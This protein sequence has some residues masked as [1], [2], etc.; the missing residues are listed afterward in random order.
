MPACSYSFAHHV[1]ELQVS[2]A[3]CAGRSGWR[4]VAALCGS[5]VRPCAWAPFWVGGV[6]G[7]MEGRP[8]GS[9]GK[10]WGNALGCR[11]VRGSTGEG[12]LGCSRRVERCRIPKNGLRECVRNRRCGIGVAESALRNRRCGIGVAEQRTI[13]P[14]ARLTVTLTVRNAVWNVCGIGVAE[15]ALWN[16]LAN[17]MANCLADVGRT[18][19]FTSVRLTLGLTMEL[20]MNC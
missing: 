9:P 6:W 14:R 18:V 15:S 12:G 5:L 2:T 19:C 10:P 13:W 8:S 4:G 7:P 11:L 3:T 1:C 17:G 20:T 16:G